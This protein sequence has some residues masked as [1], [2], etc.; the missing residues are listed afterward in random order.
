MSGY[1]Y[2][3]GNHGQHEHYGYDSKTGESFYHG[4]NFETDNNKLK[5]PTFNVGSLSY[6]SFPVYQIN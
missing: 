3:K 5:L 4:S 2:D 6:L 1:V